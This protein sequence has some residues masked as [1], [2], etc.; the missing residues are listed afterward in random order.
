MAQN[1][2]GSLLAVSRE[3]CLQ[4]CQ[5]AAPQCD[6]VSYNP[7]LQTCFLKSKGSATNC[8]VRPA[9]HHEHPLLIPQY[10]CCLPQ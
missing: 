3:G 4:A 7:T 10:V 5:A 6:S 9:R 2:F 8:P 1:G